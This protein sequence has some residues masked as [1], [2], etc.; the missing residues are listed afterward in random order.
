[1]RKSLTL[2]TLLLSLA[3]LLPLEG[4]QHGS[5]ASEALVTIQTSSERKATHTT[6]LPLGTIQATPECEATCPTSDKRCVPRVMGTISLYPPAGNPE[7]VAANAMTGRV[8]VVDGSRHVS[9]LHGDEL[10]T[11]LSVG[12]QSRPA[13]AVDEE[14]DWVYVVNA[15]DDSV[16]VIRGTE[17]ITT[18][19][20]AGREPTDVA[21]EP[22]S[23]R[24][25]V[26]S[27]YRKFPPFGEVPVVEGSVS[28]LDGDQVVGVI[29]L[30]DVVV[31]HVVVD[32]VG[33]YVYAGGFSGSLADIVG[34]VVVIK[35]MEEVARFDVGSAVK[36]MD[37]DPRTGDVYVLSAFGYLTRVQGLEMKNTIE[38][39]GEG[40]TVRNMRV[41]PLTGDVY[42]VDFTRGEVVVVRDMEVI[43]RLPVGWS[44]L[45]MVIDPLTGNVYVA[46]F[47][48]DT[49][50]VIHGTE[51]LATIDVGWYP[52]GIGVNPAN[53]WVYV[54]NTNDHTVTVLGFREEE[55]Y[56]IFLPLVL[57]S[58]MAAA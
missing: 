49:V 40:G 37:V 54:S 43:D 48:D 4:C 26:V 34:K 52:Y 8:Y 33:G 16:T 55:G 13:L 9:V 22:V 32:A 45:K 41:H 53:G 31:Q 15:Y 42:V 12:N 3:L 20:T 1:M 39:E 6:P 51:V 19:E 44:P 2:K 23:G 5:G 21:V 7:D 57:K 14:R 35:G 10:V 24:A 18:L 38:V 29:P 56:H 50:T 30:G 11:T 47:M 28:V 46:N 58:H 17:I 27:G 25:Y 36:A